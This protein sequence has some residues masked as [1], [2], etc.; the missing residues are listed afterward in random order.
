VRFCKSD[1]DTERLEKAGPA[2]IVLRRDTGHLLH[3]DYCELTDGVLTCITERGI[4][5][6]P[7]RELREIRW[8]DRAISDRALD[9]R[10]AA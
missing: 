5:S 1:T 8:R 6:W 2:D 10:R 9:G 3:A 7:V 4:R